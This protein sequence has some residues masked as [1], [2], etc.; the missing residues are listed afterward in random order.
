MAELRHQIFEMFQQSQYWPEERMLEYQHS[1]L[2]Q[3]LTH[4]KKNVPFYKNR[5][6]A[7]LR[8]D[9][10]IDWS[11]WLEIPIV[12]RHHLVEHRESMLALELPAGHGSTWEDFSSGSSGSPVT[13][14]HNHLEGWVAE[15]AVFRAQLWHGMDWSKHVVHWMGDDDGFAPWPE[16]KVQDSW[17]PYWLA[18]EQRGQKYFINRNT[19]EDRVLEF[20]LRKNTTYLASRPKSL[21]SLAL[22]SQRLGIPANFECVTVFGTG[23]DDDVRQDFHDIFGAKVLSLYSSGEGNKMACSCETG[24]HYHVNAELTFLEVLD[25]VGNPCAIGQPGRAIFTSI[26]NTAQ[27]LI[28][29]DQGDIVIRGPACSCGKT[30]PVLQAISGRMTHLF[31]FPD[32]SI[33]APSLPARKFNAG[34]GSKTWQLVQTGP[35]SLELRYVRTDPQVNLDQVFAANMI[36]Q[37]IGKNIQLSFLELST[38]PL[39]KSGKFIQYKSEMPNNDR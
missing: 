6:D 18:K 39:T 4:A 30:L 24:K 36:R 8:Q 29:Y 2:A 27:P 23:V 22:A 33:M 35:L 13:T 9:G 34:F 10:A 11:G 37:C 28:R 32:G 7:V 20:A 1:Q 5:L 16:G 21:Q 38:I 14:R 17:A 25:D 15:A 26:F 19:P 31:R 12:Q 3:L